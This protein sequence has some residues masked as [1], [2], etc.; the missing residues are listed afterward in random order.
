MLLK[1]LSSIRSVEDATPAQ[2]ESHNPQHPVFQA[3]AQPQMP[4]SHVPLIG[5]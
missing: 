5:L 1:N 3:N 2:D 4:I